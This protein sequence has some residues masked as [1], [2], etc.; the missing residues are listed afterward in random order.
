MTERSVELP[1]PLCLKRGPERGKHLFKI[2]EMSGCLMVEVGE[3]EGTHYRRLL[4]KFL[5]EGGLDGFD[6][7]GRYELGALEHVWHC[8]RELSG[9]E[10]GDLQIDCREDQEQ[11]VQP[12]DQKTDQAEVVFR[13]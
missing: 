6:R 5:R 2:I 11:S 7:A 9:G 1:I 10:A 4:A 8:I 3:R 12:Q 13:E